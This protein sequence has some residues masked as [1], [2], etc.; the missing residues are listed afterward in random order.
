MQTK[1]VGSNALGVTSGGSRVT[2]D[3]NVAR[4]VATI[5]YHTTRYLEKRNEHDR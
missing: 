2:L 1:S 3:L 4:W 5:K